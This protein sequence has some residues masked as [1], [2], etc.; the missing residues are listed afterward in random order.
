MK[1]TSIS[2]VTA[3]LMICTA[4]FFDA[5]QALIGWIPL[6]GNA[7]A[8]LFS[9]FVFMTFFLWFKLHDIKM[10]TPKRLLAMVGGG[11]IELVPYIN[12]LPAWTMVV[13]FLIGT[14]R[15]TEMAGKNPLVGKALGA[16]AG[17][18][19][20]NKNQEPPHVPFVDK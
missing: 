8:A 12:L 20:L 14:T 16:A 6:I 1:K 7:I 3:V 5:I 17:I 2:D 11:V 9:I 18:K 4:L 13:V 10:L 15:V 19:G